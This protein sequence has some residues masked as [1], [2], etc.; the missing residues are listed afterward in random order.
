MNNLALLAISFLISLI[1]WRMVSTRQK[2]GRMGLSALA[3]FLLACMGIYASVVFIL[4]SFGQIPGWLWAIYTII[5]LYFVAVALYWIWS[6][7]ATWRNWVLLW[8]TT[9]LWGQSGRPRPEA[10]THI[11]Q[12]LRLQ[13][14]TIPEWVASFLFVLLQ[15]KARRI[16]APK[17]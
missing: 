14:C 17:S 13:G 2:P 11:T 3:L 12:T 15:Q 6:L 7:Q 10:V 16:T 9:K 4:P 8:S 5:P 1:A